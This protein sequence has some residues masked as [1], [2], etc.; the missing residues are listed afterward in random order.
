MLST[1]NGGS[2][3]RL[4]DPLHVIGAVDCNQHAPN[5]VAALHSA[6]DRSEDV[7]SLVLVVLL[8]SMLYVPQTCIVIIRVHAASLHKE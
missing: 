7:L 5:A 6:G 3:R 8:S 2:Q 1:W 4:A